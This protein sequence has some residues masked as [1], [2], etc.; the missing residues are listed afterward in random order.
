GGLVLPAVGSA[1]GVGGTSF[2]TDV[3]LTNTREAAQQVLV[4]WLPQAGGVEA[5]ASFSLTI[6]SGGATVSDISA[7]LGISGI[8]S[9]ALLP[10]DADG[11]VDANASIEPSARVW[12][13]PPGGLAPRSQSV[14][15][16][17]GPALADNAQLGV[18]HLRHDEEFRTNVGVVNLSSET[19]QFTIQ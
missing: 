9:L 8:G 11:N 19:H 7:R 14:V 13:H 18:A 17:R 12:A 3:T 1:D 5:P 2:T 15:A 10:I 6:L 16:A 4:S